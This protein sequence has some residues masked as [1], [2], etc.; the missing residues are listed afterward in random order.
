VSLQAN[1]PQGAHIGAGR[2]CAKS[3]AIEEGSGADG[4]ACIHT[5]TGSGGLGRLKGGEGA[6]YVMPAWWAK[7]LVFL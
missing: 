5:G 6:A 7:L 1:W 4:A 2:R 3:D